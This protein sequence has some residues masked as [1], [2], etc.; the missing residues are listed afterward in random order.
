MGD[1][2]DW[3]LW[4]GLAENIEITIRHYRDAGRPD[5]LTAAEITRQVKVLVFQVFELGMDDI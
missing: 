2:K 4:D 5:A 3:G 1:S